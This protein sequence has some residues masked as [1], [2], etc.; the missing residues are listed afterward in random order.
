MTNGGTQHI[1]Q[2]GDAVLVHMAPGVEIPG[3]IEDQKDGKFQVRL[4]QPWA[5]DSGAKTGDLWTS[6]D[7]LAAYV[8]EETGGQ[9]ALPKP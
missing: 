4:A 5:D 9:Q 7:K 3:V 1:Y 8:E 6:P 2:V